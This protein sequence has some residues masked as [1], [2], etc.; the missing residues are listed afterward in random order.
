VARAELDVERLLGALTG[1]GVDYVVI[2]GIAAVLWGSGRNT[3]DLDVCPAP[4]AA[5][6]DA[7]GKAL[8][9]VN[10]RLRDVQDDVPFIVDGSTLSGLEILTL[11]TD[12]GALDV[13]MRPGGTKYERL[14]RRA[15]RLDVGPFAVLVASIDDLIEMKRAAG[16][17]K[18]DLDIEELE[19]IRRLARRA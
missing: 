16:R 19:V 4:D 12:A 11:S 1:H 15:Q 2:G 13:L 14:R 9:A 8:T 6:L 10:A 3:F 17:P 18:D 7:L 5:N